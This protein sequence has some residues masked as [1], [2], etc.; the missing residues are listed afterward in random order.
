MGGGG[1]RLNDS[2]GTLPLVTWDAEMKWNM[3]R[4]EKDLHRACEMIC[5]FC[6]KIGIND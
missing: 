3:I 2:P 1:L 5:M 4:D 6:V